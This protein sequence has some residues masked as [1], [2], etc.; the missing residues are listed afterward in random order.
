M[1]NHI[2]N[3]LRVKGRRE[4]V[5]KL[6]ESIK[7]EERDID[8]EKIIP[9]P[10]HI[11]RGNLSREKELKYGKENC[12]YDWS[13]NNW[14]TKWNAYDIYKSS[15]DTILFDTAWAGVPNLMNE[16]SKQHPNVELHYKYA[17]EDTGHNVD[18]HIIKNG[19]DLCSD[20]Q[21]E[22]KEAYEIYI[23]LKGKSNCLYFDEKI[24]NYVMK[25]CDE[26]EGC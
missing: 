16:L 3:K 12:W 23:E 4:D 10:N 11:Y 9:M 17:D 14:G 24:D 1:P 13:C 7:S 21:S 15:E 5:E 18:E 25:D 20:I 26:C 8:F 22:S 19:S 2:T 6:F